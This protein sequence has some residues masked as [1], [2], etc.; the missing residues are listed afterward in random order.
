MAP[1]GKKGLKTEEEVKA[2]RQD[3]VVSSQ[4]GCAELQLEKPKLASSKM[5]KDKYAEENKIRNSM[6]R[7]FKKSPKAEKVW[8]EIE[9]LPGRGAAK[10]LKKRV[11]MFAYRDCEEVDGEAFGEHFWEEVSAINVTE[12]KSL[13]GVWCTK[14]RLG[15]LVGAAEAEDMIQGNEL[16][17]KESA[18]GRPLYWFVEEKESRSASKIHTWSAKQGPVRLRNREMQEAL[19]HYDSAEVTPIAFDASGPGAAMKRPAAAMAIKDGK[20]DQEEPERKCMKKPVGVGLKVDIE[21]SIQ[22]VIRM[23]LA[24]HK[25]VNAAMICSSKMK[26]PGV[27]K[28][29]KPLAVEL[30]SNIQAFKPLQQEAPNMK[31]KK[32]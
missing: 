27:Y 7:K 9:A 1:K 29:C 26:R 20:V 13:D 15:T 4:E 19:E 25:L 18:S 6:R 5:Y 11:F 17:T 16:P 28:L 14:G 10:N 22:E 31:V 24:S 30:D 8:K 32:M 2:E 3:E 23:S 21:K 12:T